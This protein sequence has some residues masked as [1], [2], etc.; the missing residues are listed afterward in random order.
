LLSTAP[1]KCDDAVKL[2]E[3]A[4]GRRVRHARDAMHGRPASARE[5]NYLGL[6]VGDPIL[7]GAHEWSDDEGIIEYGEWC[8][9][10]WQVIGYE[11]TPGE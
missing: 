4:T 8:L 3:E 2:I 7:A 1:R 9:P 5:A 11:Y 10:K 6:P